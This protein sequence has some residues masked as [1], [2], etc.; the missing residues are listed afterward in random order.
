MKVG[1][2]DMAWENVCKSF[3][4]KMMKKKKGKKDV[5]SSSSPSSSSSSS[6]SRRKKKGK[7][8]KRS[9][10]RSQSPSAGEEL[11]SE[12]ATAAESPEVTKAKS[13]VLQTLMALK[14]ESKESRMKS[15]RKLLREWHPDKNSDKLEVAT[16]VFQFIQKGKALIGIESSR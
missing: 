5:S 7:K 16:A 9:S 10:S 6:S 4:D 12:V 15:F 11:Q 1:S 2:S 14:Q 3:R 8:R 13:E